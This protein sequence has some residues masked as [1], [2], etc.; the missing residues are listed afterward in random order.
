MDK[1]REA[2]NIEYVI[3][4]TGRAVKLLVRLGEIRAAEGCFLAPLV[5]ET[6]EDAYRS[7]YDVRRIF[8]QFIGNRFYY[9]YLYDSPFSDYP[10]SHNYINMI[11]AEQ[12]REA[13]RR[14]V[15]EA[16]GYDGDVSLEELMEEGKDQG[17]ERDLTADIA[18]GKVI[19]E[20]VAER[21]EARKPG[22]SVTAALYVEGLN[23]R[24]IAEERGMNAWTVR[25]DLKKIEEEMRRYLSAE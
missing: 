19:L 7:G 16:L 13:R 15:K 10:C 6:K 20:E 2:E 12:N 21:L 9:C 4:E 24:E 1:K 23:A 14:R 25:E 5:F 22:L 17:T 11:K 8:R 18:Y 3:P